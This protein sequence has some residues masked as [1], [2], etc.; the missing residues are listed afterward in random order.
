MGKMDETTVKCKIC[1]KPYK[2]YAFFVGDQ[3][4]CPDCIREANR[5]STKYTQ[6]GGHD[7]R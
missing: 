7:G 1:G 4:A 3:S 2:V 5:N 6:S